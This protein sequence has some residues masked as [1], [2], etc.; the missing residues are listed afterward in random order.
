MLKTVTLAA[1]K[2]NLTIICCTILLALPLFAQEKEKKAPHPATTAVLTWVKAVKS[3]TLTPKDTPFRPKDL[4]ALKSASNNEGDVQKKLAEFIIENKKGLHFVLNK[5]N[6]TKGFL[7]SD[8]KKRLSMVKEG[9]RWFIDTLASLRTIKEEA[10]KETVLADIRALTSN[11]EMYKN[12]G[13][14]YPSVEQ[15]LKSLVK[16]PN[17]SPRPRRWVQSID[18][19]DSLNDPWGNPYQYRLVDDA[20]Q[21]SSLGPDGKISKDDIA[22]SKIVR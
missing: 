13:G 20:P 19:V 11:L 10:Q 17:S 6:P 8:D 15:G 18:S 3:D 22:L 1:I 4:V 9:D 2:M 12:I 21:I 16:K 5:K 14:R 7:I